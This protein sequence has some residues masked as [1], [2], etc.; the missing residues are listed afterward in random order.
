MTALHPLQNEIITMLCRQMKMR[1]QPVFLT[2]HLH[3]LRIRFRRIN[4]RQPQPAQT[5][6]L[7][8][9]GLHQ[10]AKTR[11]PG[12]I[13]SPRGDV[14]TG[15]HNFASATINKPCRRVDHLRDAGRAVVAAA[16][17]NDAEGAAVVTSLLNLQ[18]AA[19][20]CGESVQHMR[21]GLAHLHDVAD[22]HRFGVA[23]LQ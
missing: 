4:R 21:R 6:N 19:G 14:D 7:A 15:Q 17:G 11:T 3:Q 10:Q 18:K 9:K 12:K 23:C 1:H 8:K 20:M 16:I 5:G 2:K 22:N 13:A